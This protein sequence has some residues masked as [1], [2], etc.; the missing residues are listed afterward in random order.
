M[1]DMSMTCIMMSSIRNNSE[2]LPEI[3]C[4]VITQDESSTVP[5]SSVCRM[6]SL[7][8]TKVLEVGFLFDTEVCRREIQTDMAPKRSESKN[9]DIPIEQDIRENLIIKLEKQAFFGVSV[10]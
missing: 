8:F 1:I 10:L 6:S 3:I 9:L 7:R 4:Y 5:A 2:I